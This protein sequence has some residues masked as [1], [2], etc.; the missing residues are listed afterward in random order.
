MCKV[1]NIRTYREPYVY[2]GRRSRFGNPFRIGPDGDRAEVIGK[3]RCWFHKR[4]ASSRF[5]A[6]VLALR[7]KALG[8]HCKPLPCHGDVIVEY[9]KENP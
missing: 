4:L 3:Y 7:G 8:C 2:I 1:V 6:T 5:K 9:L